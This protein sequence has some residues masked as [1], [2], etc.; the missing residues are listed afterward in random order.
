MKTHPF[1]R[2]IRSLIAVLSMA[3][4]MPSCAPDG[5]FEQEIDLPELEDKPRL[6]LNAFA[7]V[8]DSSDNVLIA[9][10]TKSTPP[11]GS[12]AP[13]FINDAVVTLLEDDQPVGTGHYKKFFW[14][15]ANGQ[16][17]YLAGYVFDFQNFTH[18]KKYTLK[19]TTTE[20]PTLE[21]S[22]YL[23]YPPKIT[24]WKYMPEG[25]VDPPAGMTYDLIELQLD[26]LRQDQAMVIQVADTTEQFV[27]TLTK[28]SS[29]YFQLNSYTL[30][31]RNKDIFDT[32]NGVIRIPI[33]PTDLR[34][35][36]GLILYLHHIN[37]DHFQF[38]RDYSYNKA[39]SLIQDKSPIS[40]NV[41]GGN[42]LF[43][44]EYVQEYEITP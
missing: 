6:T 7:E 37:L 27:Y 8:S 28:Y 4:L 2:H 35:T 30:L 10:V 17:R 29:E 1:F 15:E 22:Q 43:A 19:V 12:H 26:Q 40:T 9:F 13:I 34:S 38:L 20:Y 18:G 31:V 44:L 3:W 23:P 33:I 14:H 5:F 16:L 36:K 39:T 41:V 42:G 11:S 21:S 24:S 32:S 25:Y